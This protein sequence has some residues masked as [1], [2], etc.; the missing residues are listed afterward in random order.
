MTARA[1]LNA[2]VALRLSAIAG[3]VLLLTGCSV[4]Q[5]AVNVIGDALSTGGGVYAS[6]NDAQLIREALPFGLKTFESLLELSPRHRGLLL[7]AARGFTAYAY[8]IQDQ[9]DQLD[10]ID[11]PKAQ[12]LRGRA[13]RLYLRGRDYALRGLDSHFPGFTAALNDDRA[14]A[15]RATTQDDVPFLYWAGVAWAAAAATAKN[16]PGLLINLPIAGALVRR[17]LA[18][19]EGYDS[20][21]AH[22][23]FISFEANRPGGS[24]ERAREHYQQ[25]LNF[26]RGQRASVYLS[27]AESVALREQNLVEFKGLIQAALAVEAGK[28]P[29]F[30]LANTVAQQ[31]G[32]W[33]QSR[34]NDLFVDAE[35]QEDKRK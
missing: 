3:L 19:N 16:D 20:G 7:A 18:L 1:T 10:A 8:L 14:A 13:S 27:L 35:S 22:E 2:A 12:R 28:Y 4:R 9:A 23:F 34:I 6:D 24:I 30:R 25:T 5:V 11:L 32:E 29:Q 21:A 15:L 31:R 17:V 33:L 26:S